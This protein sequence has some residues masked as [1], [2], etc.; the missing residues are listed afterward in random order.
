LSPRR[1][2]EYGTIG[3]PNPNNRPLPDR[4][5][6]QLTQLVD[7]GRMPPPRS[8]TNAHSPAIR[9]TTSSAVNIRGICGHPDRSICKR[10]NF[11]C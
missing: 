8:S 1:Y 2:L 3:N 6:P 4:V 10:C 7:A 9:R 5:A 11:Q